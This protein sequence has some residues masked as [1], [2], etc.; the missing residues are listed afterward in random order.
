MYNEHTGVGLD[1]FKCT[2]CG[3]VPFCTVR[4]VRMGSA[5]VLGLSLTVVGV[6][7]MFVSP[8]VDVNG[9]RALKPVCDV[10][11]IWTDEFPNETVTEP[12]GLLARRRLLLRCDQV[13]VI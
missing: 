12:S 11:V 8:H 13:E 6:V 3:G 2:R 4:R 10:R 7:C 5:L 1:S 9:L